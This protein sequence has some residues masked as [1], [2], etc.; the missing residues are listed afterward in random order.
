MSNLKKSF[1]ASRRI[2]VEGTGEDQ[3]I[4]V[5]FREVTLTDTVTTQG[6]VKNDPV[7]LYDTGGVYHEEDYEINI[8]NGIPKIREQWIDDRADIEPYEG[9]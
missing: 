9:R 8:D 3:D 6:V 1:P 4:K 2:F 5:P 7:V